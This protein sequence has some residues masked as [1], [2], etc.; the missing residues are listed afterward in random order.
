[1]SEFFQLQ[2][3][4]KVIWEA[5]PL[6]GLKWMWFFPSLVPAV[7]FGFFI[8]SFFSAIVASLAGSIFFLPIALVI[9]VLILIFAYV[10]ALLRYNKEYYWIT[11]HRVIRKKGFI[12]Y[13]VYSIPMER[14]SDVIISRSFVERIF[15]FSSIHVQSLAGQVSFQGSRF[16]GEG[17][18]AAIPNPEELQKMIFELVN[19]NRKEKKLGI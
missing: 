6:P 18:L 9:F 13:S 8:G 7:I 12:G 11:T 2:E 14:I 10:C 16:G 17:Y 4:E 1:M 15:G 5:K 3:N 19:K